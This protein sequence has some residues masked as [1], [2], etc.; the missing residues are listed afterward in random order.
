ML[1]ARNFWANGVGLSVCL[2]FFYACSHVQPTAHADNSDN[3]FGALQK[4]LISDGFD[5]S[6][7]RRLYSNPQVRFD[8]KRVSMYFV[9]K[10]SKLNYGQFL[11][12]GSVEK[13]RIYMKT[14][15]AKLAEAEKMYG[16]DKE[17]ITGILLVETRLGTYIG[18]SNVLN[19]LSTM[20]ALLDE[21]V[22]N[23]LWEKIPSSTR[24][25]RE[26]FE[27]KA[28]K[29][30]GWAYNELKSFLTYTAGEKI[31]PMGI[32]GSYAGAMGI[33]QFMPSNIL[34]L[35][36]DGDNNGHIDLFNHSDAIMS[37]ANYLN[38]YGWYP[39][40]DREGAF[41]VVYQY[42]HSKYYVNTILD[43]AKVLRG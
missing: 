35:A 9:H 7:I 36:R 34:T 26:E 27:A 14:H 43:I 10:E 3:Y 1:N 22:R 13:A 15:R 31:N 33:C 38:H 16:V 25:T 37:V 17:I 32:N 8:T 28:E 11:E 39:G 19:V 30:S 24:L 2:L 21:G 23:M 29:K 42:N 40:I 5:E 41:R 18:K 4:R 6:G 20:A 12:R